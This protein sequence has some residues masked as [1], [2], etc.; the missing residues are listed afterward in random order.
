MLRAKKS[1][2]AGFKN[3]MKLWS[4][5]IVNASLKETKTCKKGIPYRRPYRTKVTKFWK[6]DENFP[7]QFF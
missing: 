4:K 7:Q 3:I 1:G 2:E 6:G 5:F